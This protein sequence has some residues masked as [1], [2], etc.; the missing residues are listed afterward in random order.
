[1]IEAVAHAVAHTDSWAVFAHTDSGAVFAWATSHSRSSFQIAI[2]ECGLLEDGLNN[3]S[4]N[5]KFWSCRQVVV[6]MKRE[7]LII[8]QNLQKI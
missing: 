5:S 2:P 8:L 3:D 4:G 7:F 6:G 1:M